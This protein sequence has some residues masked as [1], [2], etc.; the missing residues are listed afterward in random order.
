MAGAGSLDSG[1]L[2]EAEAQE[3]GQLC[4]GRG[5]GTGSVRPLGPG[6]QCHGSQDPGVW[7]RMGVRGRGWSASPIPG[8]PVRQEMGLVPAGASWAQSSHVT[9]CSVSLGGK[10]AQG[11]WGRGRACVWPRT[12]GLPGIRIQLAAR[13]ALPAAGTGVLVL[14]PGAPPPGSQ[15][16]AGPVRWVAAWP[17]HASIHNSRASGTCL[18]GPV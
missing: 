9:F 8:H 5:G 15:P 2:R 16:G 6:A 1:P 10:Q 3:P 17:R 13:C 18:I 4:W 11:R 14:S 12:G 7:A